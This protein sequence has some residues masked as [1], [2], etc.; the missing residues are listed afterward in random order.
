MN[1]VQFATV[2]LIVEALWETCKMFITNGKKINM[3]RIGAVAFGELIAISG[4]ID[5][6][7]SVGI[8]LRVPLVG[9]ILTG[10][11]VSRGANFMHD[12]V[13]SV[14]NVYQGSKI[15]GIKK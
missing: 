14:G 4:G 2:A 8:N 11:L 15:E 10:L 5:F 13:A 1:L 7:A 6:L 12:I 9:M 3:D